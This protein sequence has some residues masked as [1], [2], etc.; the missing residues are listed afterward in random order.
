VVRKVLGF[1]ALG[2]GGFLLVAGLV[3]LLWAPGVVKRTPLD[4]DS[5]TLLSGQAQRLDPATGDVEDAEVLAVSRN[6]VD[7]EISDDDVVAFVANTCLNVDEGQEPACLRGDD[8]RVINNSEPDVF[9]TDRRTGESLSAEASAEL[10]PADAVPHEGLVNKFP[11]DTPQADQQLWDG[12]LGEAVTA[13]Y[14]GEDEIE[15]LPVYRFTTQ[16]DDQPATVVGDIEG[17]Y[18]S[19]KT[20]WVDPRTGSI[21]DQE[22]SEQR[23]TEDG[24]TLLD[25]ELSFTDEQ[26]ADNVASAEDSIGTIDTI[27]R[28]VPVVGLVGGAVLLVGGF[29]LLRGSRGARGRRSGPSGPAADR[30]APAA[31]SV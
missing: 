27:T 15:G 21:I 16:V 13:T 31:A 5:T 26:V 8:E 18:S 22:Q 10:L 11:F 14:D 12:L 25:L 4:T 2:L 3:A 1:V 28:T 23:T 30:D 17:R 20:V 19:Q 9:A 7:S 6:R 29:L 24:D